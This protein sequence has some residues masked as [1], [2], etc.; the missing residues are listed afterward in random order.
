MVKYSDNNLGYPP[1]Q[2]FL[3]LTLTILGAMPAIVF[4]L[5]GR[6]EPRIALIFAG[7]GIAF[8]VCI[9]L[10]IWIDAQRKQNRRDQHPNQPWMWRQDWAVGRIESSTQNNRGTLE[11]G[12]F[13]CLT[14]AIILIACDRFIEVM[15]G[16]IH[17]YAILFS[18]GSIVLFYFWMVQRARDKKFSKTVFAMHPV[19]V[20]PGDRL[21][22][23]IQV[24]SFESATTAHLWVRCMKVTR[25]RGSRNW[26]FDP[27]WQQSW[28]VVTASI[29]ASTGGGIIPVDIQTSEDAPG[30]SNHGT[31]AGMW[32]NE[33]VFYWDLG[34]TADF[35]HGPNLSA[36]FEVPVFKLDKGLH[37]DA[38]RPYLMGFWPVMLRLVRWGMI[39]AAAYL[40]LN[41]LLPY[42]STAIPYSWEKRIFADLRISSTANT[43]VTDQLNSLGL[44]L[45]DGVSDRS[46]NF[47][48]LYAD[49]GEVNAYAYPGGTIVV[50]RGL[51]SE[52]RSPEELAGVM[53]HEIA[54]VLRRHALQQWLH[55]AGTFALFRL[56]LGIPGSADDYIR[57]L[58]NL[59]YSRKDEQEADQ[60]GLMILHNAGLSQEGM[61]NVFERWSNTDTSDNRF[62]RFLSTHPANQERVQYLRQ[63]L[64]GQPP[65][66]VQTAPRIDW[67]KLR[68]SVAA[69]TSGS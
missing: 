64:A 21:R 36:R 52:L 15:R 2:K 58:A 12:F 67:R 66:R 4:S 29:D 57:G 19:P 61:I 44:Q 68:I 55:N 53:A 11:T 62:Q 56:I 42:V 26:H 27:V 13:A 48:F 3:A 35:S 43:G 9:P 7:F 54:H 25:P 14:I 16:L 37:S 18:V 38:K 49:D 8:I 45:L 46:Y 60:E 41:F 30:T 24:P 5:V 28:D 47:R 31:S 51:I 69:K 63:I 65:E 10:P 33:P 59:H 39:G 17:L 34:V 20:Q 23:Q 1:G 6:F 32:W 40:A 50:H 22:G